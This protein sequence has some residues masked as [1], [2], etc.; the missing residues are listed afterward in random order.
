[1]KK[2]VAIVI[3]LISILLV[4]ALLLWAI[5]NSSGGSGEAG[6]INIH[7]VSPGG[8]DYFAT[9]ITATNFTVGWSIFPDLPPWAEDD[10]SASNHLEWLTLSVSSYLWNPDTVSW[11]FAPASYG[12]GVSWES[13][14]PHQT[15]QIPG[16]ITL[17]PIPDRD[18]SSDVR[19]RFVA[20][21]ECGDS[22]GTNWYSESAEVEKSYRYVPPITPSF[23]ITPTNPKEGNTIQCTSAVVTAS[24]EIEII[25]YRWE[26][27][28]PLDGSWVNVLGEGANASSVE[29]EPHAYWPPSAGRYNIT[30]KAACKWENVSYI[31]DKS[32][33]STTIEKD[34]EIL[35]T[36]EPVNASFTI[37]PANPSTHNIVYFN[38]TSKSAF[39]KDDIRW[40]VNGDS[41]W[42]FRLLG[43]D[44]SYKWDNL[45]QIGWNWSNPST[46]TYNVSLWINTTAG[47][48]DSVERTFEIK[49]TSNAVGMSADTGGVIADGTSS[50]KI[51]VTLPS[52]STQT[53]TL[54]DGK[55]T[56]TETAING[57]AIFTYVPDTGKLGL[58]PSDIPPE[59]ADIILTATAGGQSETINLKVYRKPILL[60]HGLWSDGHMWDKMKGWLQN[61][62]FT[63]YTI[64]YPNVASPAA[65]AT[66]QFDD[67]IQAVKKNFSQQYN[68]NITKIDVIAHSM[69][70]VIV[71]YY[72]N[73]FQGSPD[74]D[75]HTLI[76]VGTPHKGS[77]WPKI[78]YDWMNLR[79]K[80]G[81]IL[82]TTQHLLPE[83]WMLKMG[84][85]LDALMPDS[86]FISDLNSQANNIYVDYHAICGTNNLLSTLALIDIYKEGLAGRLLSWSRPSFIDGDGVVE[87]NS[88][89]YAEAI[90]D[91]YYV[92]AWHC[93]EGSNYGVFEISSQIL[94]GQEG[95][96]PSIY[97]APES[98]TLKVGYF[99]STTETF[100]LLKKGIISGIT[101]KEL[102]VG[103]EIE[104]GDVL[105]ILYDDYECQLS[106]GDF[107]QVK[108]NVHYMN[109]QIGTLYVQAKFKEDRWTILKPLIRIDVL[110]PNT[111]HI[112]NEWF[113]ALKLRFNYRGPLIVFTDN[114][115]M[116]SPDPDLLISI[117]G[118]NNTEISLLEG[119]ITV[120]DN[121]NKTE[122]VKV[123]QA[124]TLYPDSSM[125][126][127]TTFELSTI[128]KWWATIK[129]SDHVL[130]NNVNSDGNP[131]K[132]TTIFNTEDMVY[133][134]LGLANAS[135]G[136]KVR[137]L[138]QGPNNLTEESLYTI[139]WEGEGLCYAWL[140]LS[141]YGERTT[142]SWN[143][144]VYV[145][146]EMSS[147]AYFDVEK[148]PTDTPGFEIMLL[149]GAIAG[150]L[151]IM[152]KKD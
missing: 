22:Y 72:I 5:P 26:V 97:K 63:V 105:E 27:Y 130:C 49:D 84:P 21:M 96:I 7:W 118:T 70:G 87:L 8:G 152:K 121:Y 120:F 100:K 6:I 147:I 95:Q 32:Y 61:D 82:L 25:N 17:S 116:A 30:L 110:S 122:N 127:P 68:A 136:D 113:F 40:K 144:T 59:G 102:K 138:F 69:G 35:P 75:I 142:G 19:I 66:N 92:N 38:D 15:A 135:E 86:Q 77:P 106:K 124:V 23:T 151:V 114:G 108:I 53:V 16:F 79:S 48:T 139:D 58:S 146:G 129:V 36:A 67:R 119:N 112:R 20:K 134:W 145:N 90:K 41:L 137:W 148:T 3:F 91:G 94:K 60:V 101:D 9:R 93:G 34:V 56:L 37:E 132:V 71:R 43:N 74:V 62:G 14:P 141:E 64:D 50:A 125:E 44:I 31:S 4:Q 123:G 143:V 29:W 39:P 150:V 89:R 140:N 2:K 42:N 54:A 78:Y 111:F 85:A 76:T 57:A 10:P 128:D 47:Y 98:P 33:W 73:Q 1:M 65:V 11:E 24:P 115:L 133:S 81:I 104:A 13:K 99:Y 28:D 46:G 55:T 103:D 12:F 126:T 80:T 52:T 117:D 88:Q 83:G 18:K 45:N 131:V 109:Q 107:A 149:I 51:T